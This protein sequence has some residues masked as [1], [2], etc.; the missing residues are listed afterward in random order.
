MT[1]LSLKARLALAGTLAILA[2]LGLSAIGLTALFGSHAERRAALELSVHLDQLLSGLEQQDTRLAMTI[3]PADPRFDRPYSGLYWQ[4]AADGKVLRS[5]S[6]WDFELPLAQAG[7]GA[8]PRSSGLYEL[9]GPDRKPVLALIRNVTLPV[10]DGGTEVTAVVALDSTEIATARWK[11]AVDLAPYLLLLGGALAMAGWLQMTVG[12]RPLR[13]L[14]KRTAALRRGD[15]ARMGGDWPAE[16]EPLA[17]EIDELLSARESDVQRAR[18]RAGDLAHGLKTPLQALL[19]EAGRLRERGETQTANDIVMIARSM[20]KRIERELVRVRT[21][22]AQRR[23]ACN[24]ATVV[25][26]VVAVLQRTP[27]GGALDWDIQVPGNVDVCI[28]ATDFSE[29]FGALAENAAR[30]AR[31]RITVSARTDGSTLVL[32]LRDDGPGIREDRLARLRNGQERADE[33]ATGDGLGLAI[34][35]EVV[36]TA[37][38]SI[39]LANTDTGFRARI[40]LLSKKSKFG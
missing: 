9:P 39:D 13:A 25:E 12:L 35:R 20:Q 36:E 33:S 4:F 8:S 34:A 18:A 26:G 6:L 1:R 32:D 27:E 22:G 29:A 7:A 21:Q 16:V 5:R 31:N 37:G 17:R 15:A 14:T 30:H 28:D 10:D 2:A 24:A 23:T 38:G 40:A 11:F 3:S 19:G